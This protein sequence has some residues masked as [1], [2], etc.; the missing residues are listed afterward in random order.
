MSAAVFA[1]VLL[2]AALHA[3]WNAL[4]KAGLSKQTS[5]FL[6]SLGHAF[7]ALPI[8]AT[9]P[10][11]PAGIWPWIVASALIHTAYQLFLAY[12]YERGDLSRVYPLARGAAPMIVTLVGVF[13]LADTMRPLDYAGIAVLGTGIALMARGVFSNGES[14]Q[15]LP[16]A[17][18][19]ALATAGYT[20]V[21][22]LGARAW[23]LPVAFVSWMMS[24]TAVFYVPVVVALR[25]RAVL[26]ADR[27]G[28]AIGM[29]AAA[30]SFA[31]YAIAVWAMTQAPIALV[32][33]L[34]ETSILFA[35]LLGWAVFGDRIDRQKIVAGALIVAGIVLTRL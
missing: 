34:R 30:A 10:L 27:R 33:A 1:A 15:L 12:A 19:A 4:V 13:W 11:P 35:I 20:L 5:M 17:F 22:G 6:L 21:D 18:G 14:R 25:G 7:C 23:G 29:V 31:A 32:A 2:A 26:R 16:F 28:W 3:G 8:V 9:S 24:L